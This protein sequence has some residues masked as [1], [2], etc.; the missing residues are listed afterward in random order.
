[1]VIVNSTLS[2]NIMIILGLIYMFNFIP[3]AFAQNQ[4][5]LFNPSQENLETIDALDGLL[6]TTVVAT[7]TGLSLTAATFLARVHKIET[8]TH[9][10]ES[11]SK[12]LIKGFLFFLVCLIAIFVFDMI[13]IIFK[14]NPTIMILDTFITYGLSAIGAI[15]L[16][17]GA[18]GIYSTFAN[19]ESEF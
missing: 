12:N 15:Y 14:S 7:L 13:E 1:M 16:V 6:S 5:S 19:S 4:N 11:A 2:K 10:L 8:Q 9:F 17:K 18:K 3:F